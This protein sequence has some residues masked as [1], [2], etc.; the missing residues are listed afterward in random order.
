MT[1]FDLFIFMTVFNAMNSLRIPT[2]KLICNRYNKLVHFSVSV[3]KAASPKDTTTE[4]FGTLVAGLNGAQDLSI[5]VLSCR[6]IVQS[7]MERLK[8]SSLSAT[9]LGE[10]MIG[11]LL[12]GS[13]LKGE[14]TI[15]VNFIGDSGIKNIIAISD[16]SLNV[17]GRIGVAQFAPDW[18][19]GESQ[20]QLLTGEILGDGQIQVIRNHPAWKSPMNGIVEMVNASIA[21]N[22]ALYLAQSEQKT[23]AMLFDVKV[24]NNT[25]SNALGIL[26]ERLPNACEENVEMAIKNLEAIQQKGLGS[27][28]ANILELKINDSEKQSETDYLHRILDDCLFSMEKDSIR[29]EKDASFKCTCNKSKVVRAIT[30]LD[31]IDF[32]QIVEENKEVEMKCEFCGVQY[33]LSMLEINDIARNRNRS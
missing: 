22:F 27:Y 11:T 8:L 18:A 25:C 17:R 29:W 9:A 1:I 15:Q 23:C 19:K 31:S 32:K 33:N 30:L 28:S 2:N 14:E 5:K 12:I 21:S 6:N 10:V 3:N 7:T 13:G 26:I 20:Q 4:S 16:G 24:E